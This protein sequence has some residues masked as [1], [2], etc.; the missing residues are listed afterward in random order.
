MVIFYIFIL[1]N[2]HRMHMLSSKIF[3]ICLLLPYATTKHSMLILLLFKTISSTF[4]SLSHLNILLKT[5]WCI[6]CVLDMRC[7][8]NCP[9]RRCR[10]SPTENGVFKVISRSLRTRRNSIW[11]GLKSLKVNINFEEQSRSS[12]S[13]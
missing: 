6:T 5:F 2:S 10:F 9:G 4:V 11:K 3:N 7:Q 1:I 13:I 12:W 8:I